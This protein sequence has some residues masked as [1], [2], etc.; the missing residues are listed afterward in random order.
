MLDEEA[1]KSARAKARHSSR[2]ATELASIHDSFKRIFNEILEVELTYDEILALA[3]FE[4][5]AVYDQFADG[6][7]GEPFHGEDPEYDD[8]FGRSPEFPN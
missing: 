7:I 6:G 1:V 4:L 3:E 8:P 2:I 5:Q